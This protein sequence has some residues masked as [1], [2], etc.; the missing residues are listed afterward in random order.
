MISR[1]RDLFQRNLLAKILALLLAI[2][3]WAYVMNDENPSIE[4]SFTVPL[5]LINAPE[6]Y[7]VSREVTS[8]VIHVR[9]ARS[10]FVNVD[11]KNFSAYVE[12]GSVNEGSQ[13]CRVHVIM[14]QGFEL[15]EVEPDAAEVTLDRIAAKDFPA[16]L[17][18]TG[19]TA[20]GTTVAKVSQSSQM[21][22][23]EGP[24]SL[25]SEVSRVIGYVGLSG[26]STDFSLQVPLTAINE[27]GRE[28]TGVTVNPASVKADVQLARGLTKKVVSIKP[29]AGEG[30][31][32]NLELVGMRA[33]PVKIEIAGE[34]NIINGISEI[35]T[36]PVSL[37]DVTQ[38][39]DKIVKLSPPE[40]VTVT[41]RDVT[42]HIEVK[43]K[44]AKAGK[45]KS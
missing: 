14:P 42:V 18:V 36:E 32:R 35:E 24:N 39:S 21:V 3:L 23:V 41:N 31:P 33:D 15:V 17:I 43:A 38:K 45:Q 7:Q 12:L 22:T 44:A 34:D 16:E 8:V 5:K 2:A 25:L 11:E 10:Q 1:V 29:V 4:G 27:D 19:A 6:G 28:V 9:G 37:S 20:Q 26:N 30:L 40:G 13:N